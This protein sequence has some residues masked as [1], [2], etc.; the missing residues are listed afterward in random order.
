MVETL[1][2]ELRE[3]AVERIKTN[4]M[5]QKFKFSAA[6]RQ[7]E[8]YKLSHG[9]FPRVTKHSVEEE[10]QRLL[11][12]WKTGRQRRLPSPSK[13]VPSKEEEISLDGSKNAAGLKDSF[14]ECP[15]CLRKFRV[16]RKYASHITSHY[17]GNGQSRNAALMAQAGDGRGLE[18]SSRQMSDAEREDLRYFLNDVYQ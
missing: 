6:K 15:R 16:H 4:E 18:R 7:A 17:S 11:A 5:L 8:F 3:R 1:D 10:A 14:F 9:T 2:N 12:E 13:N